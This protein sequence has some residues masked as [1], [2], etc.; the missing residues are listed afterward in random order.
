[1]RLLREALKPVAHTLVKILPFVFLEQL[2]QRLRCDG[3]AWETLQQQIGVEPDGHIKLW[4]CFVCGRNSGF[5]FA[6]FAL[7]LF[8]LF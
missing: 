1:M 7:F 2:H 5:F 3:I 4:R 8:A 6:L